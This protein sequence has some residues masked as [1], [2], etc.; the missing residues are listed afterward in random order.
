MCA[1]YTQAASL[2]LRVKKA[3]IMLAAFSVLYGFWAVAC[4]A[5]LQTG[6]FLPPIIAAVTHGLYWVASRL[7]K[8]TDQRL[9]LATKLAWSLITLVSRSTSAKCH[10]SAEGSL[11][12]N[13]HT[14]LIQGSRG[15]PEG[16]SR[17]GPEG[18][19]RVSIV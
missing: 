14:T 12:Q 16:G 18:G 9:P 8:N 4:F 17:G 2:K 19:S 3:V 13:Y 6:K 10:P 15:G 5:T 11:H 1:G 7:Q